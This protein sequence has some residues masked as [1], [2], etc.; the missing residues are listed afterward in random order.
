MRKQWIKRTISIMIFLILL[1]TCVKADNATFDQDLESAIVQL[2]NIRKQFISISESGYISHVQEQSNASNIQLIKPYT[3]QISQVRKKLETYQGQGLDKFSERKL[4]TILAVTI[5]LDEMAENLIDYLSSSDL[6]EQF[7]FYSIHLEM[8]NF[9][10]NILAQ[11][12]SSV[13]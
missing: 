5:Y 2:D 1:V 8:N 6:K 13:Y 10:T 7:K 3:A 11:V 4:K 12:K 9:I